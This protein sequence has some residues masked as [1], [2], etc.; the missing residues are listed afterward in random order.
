MNRSGSGSSIA[1]I[2]PS[3]A[4]A[5]IRR[6][7]PTSVTACEWI[8]LTSISPA[9]STSARLVPDT[10]STV[11]LSVSCCSAASCPSTPRTT[12]PP[13]ANPASCAPPADSEDRQSECSS[14][15]QKR[16]LVFV[17]VGVDPSVW[18][19]ECLGCRQILAAG[20]DQGFEWLELGPGKRTGNHWEHDWK[21]SGGE[22]RG[23]EA[24]GDRVRLVRPVARRNRAG[25]GGNGDQRFLGRRVAHLV[26]ALY[27]MA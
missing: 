20:Q 15:F 13:D 11:C 17:A 19:F 5:E 18:I 6:P 8:V 3:P 9:P 25:Q 7:S 16:V 21:P 4:R 26:N 27:T 24:L 1:S 12:W 14:S 23:R 10:I 22:D 2:V